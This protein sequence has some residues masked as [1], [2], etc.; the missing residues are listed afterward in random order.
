MERLNPALQGESPGLSSSLAL[1][2]HITREQLAIIWVLPD[3]PSCI[4][5]IAM[6]DKVGEGNAGLEKSGAE[7]MFRHQSLKSPGDIFIGLF[8]VAPPTTCLRYE[9]LRDIF[10]IGA[11][12]PPTSHTGWV[13]GG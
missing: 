5:S 7:M 9:L 4:S 12:K 11:E 3:D 10:G 2:R 13:V 6:L 1:L 8:S